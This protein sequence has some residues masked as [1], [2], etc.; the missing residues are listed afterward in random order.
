[1]VI[2]SNQ[3]PVDFDDI[4]HM[5]FTRVDPCSMPKFDLFF[6]FILIDYAYFYK[7]VFKKSSIVTIF[8]FLLICNNCSFISSTYVPVKI[9]MHDSSG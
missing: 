9:K 3:E 6:N 4:V 2:G 5:V 8:K 7:S 1:M